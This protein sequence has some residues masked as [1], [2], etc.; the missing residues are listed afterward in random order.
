MAPTLKFQSH[1]A[2][3]ASLP[4]DVSPIALA[5]Q[6]A[7]QAAVPAAK[8]CIS[9]NMPAFRLGKTFIYFAAFKNHIGVYPPVVGSEQLRRQLAPFRGPK[10]SLVF[11]LDQPVPV[12]LIAQVAAALAQEYGGVKP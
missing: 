2:Y 11:P 7:I 6:S 5:I 8:P 10:G 12:D 3:F 4:S 1:D 9:Y